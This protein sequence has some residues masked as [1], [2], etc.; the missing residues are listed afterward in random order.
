MLPVLIYLVLVLS[1]YFVARVSGIRY[2][3]ALA[4]AVSVGA[5]YLLNQMTVEDLDGGNHAEYILAAMSGIVI[6]AY[7]LYAISSDR[8]ETHVSPQ[9]VSPMY[10]SARSF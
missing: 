4:L 8:E 6:A 10:T 5:V 9:T 3:S 1:V 2:F 7:F